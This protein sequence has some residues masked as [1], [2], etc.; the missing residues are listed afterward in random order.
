MHLSHLT[1]VIQYLIVEVM[2]TWAILCALYTHGISGSSCYILC[3]FLGK[4]MVTSKFS[5]M[6]ANMATMYQGFG[7]QNLSLFYTREVHV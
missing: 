1:N 3:L 7:T 5:V 6:P 4:G 2:N